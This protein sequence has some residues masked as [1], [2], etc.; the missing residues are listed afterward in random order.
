MKKRFTFKCWNCPG[1][2]TLYRE[3]TDQQKIIVACPYCGAEGVVDL[4]PYPPVKE[5][6]RGVGNEEI[7]LW[8]R[9]LP[10]VLPTQPPE[11]S[12]SG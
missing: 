9:Q 8:E 1:T 7:I 10:D 11:S 3:I 2:Y 12:T 4:S 6:L 5:V